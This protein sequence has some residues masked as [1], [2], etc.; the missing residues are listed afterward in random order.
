IFRVPLSEH[1]GTGITAVN[2]A[3]FITILM[4]GFAAFAGGQLVG[5]LGP[6]IVGVMGGVVYGIGV[7]LAYFAQGSLVVLYLTYGLIA[8]IG[9]GLAYIIPIQVLPKWFPDRP[10]FATGI[11]VMGFGGGSAVTVPVAGYL[12]PAV[13]LFGTFGVL[14]LAYIVFVGGA[15]FFITNPPEGYSPEGHEPSEEES[16]QEEERTRDFTGALKTWQWYALWAM[17]F[18]NVTAG[19]SIIS[20]AKAIA[21]EL[22][23]AT[24]TLASVF[25]VV[26]AFANAAGRLGWATLSDYIGP[27]NV[28]LTMFLIQAVLFLLIP[29]VGRDVFILLTIFSFII[30]T[31][32]GGGFSTMPT[33]AS[34]YFGSRNVA[35]IYGAMLTAWGLATLLGPL[36]LA[37]STDITGTYDLALYISAGIMLVSAAIPLVIKPPQSPRQT[38]AGGQEAEA[39]A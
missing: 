9:L 22:G 30:L 21:S 17:L 16:S 18:L 25:V 37:I 36:V 12:V 1:F 31:C 29:L 2:W 32:Y 24:A 27:R 19:L 34:A 4:I 26:L 38:E 10:G 13:G 39:R 33:F 6:R 5:R 8:G 20:D 15:A 23:G 3:F 28:F 7:G 35:T 11:A 14:G